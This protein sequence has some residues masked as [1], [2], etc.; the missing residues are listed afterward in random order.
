MK[1]IGQRTLECCYPFRQHLTCRSHSDQKAALATGSYAPSSVGS[2][3]AMRSR[4]TTFLRYSSVETSPSNRR[5]SIS[6]IRSTSWI[7]SRSLAA[8]EAKG[9]LA[10]MGDFWAGRCSNHGSPAPTVQL[11]TNGSRLKLANEPGNRAHAQAVHLSGLRRNRIGLA[12]RQEST[13]L[14]T[15]WH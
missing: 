15:A 11:Q 14:P 3:L 6:H 1:A 13:H 4:A 2:A 10:F 8:H 9:R 7:N 12:A 5:H